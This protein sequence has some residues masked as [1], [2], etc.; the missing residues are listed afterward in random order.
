MTALKKTTP[1]AGSRQ[2]PCAVSR[3]PPHVRLVSL[4][5]D[6]RT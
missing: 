2:A 3:G 1:P 4:L 6:N 5:V